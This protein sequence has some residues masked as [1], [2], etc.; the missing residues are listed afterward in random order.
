MSAGIYD[1]TIEQGATF[2]LAISIVRATTD[3]TGY[4]ARAKVRSSFDGTGTVLA[5]FTVTNVSRI[6]G[7]YSLTLGLTATQTAALSA[8][9][10]GRIYNI[11]FWDLEM[12]DTGT[13]VERVL[14]GKALLSFEATV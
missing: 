11:G 1:L 7:T 2:N 8:T 12:I 10:S 5:T 9:G 14:Q 13:T 6:V 4:T 3:F